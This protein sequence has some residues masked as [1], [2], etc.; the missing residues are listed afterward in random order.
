MRQSLLGVE[1]FIDRGLPTD[2]DKIFWRCATDSIWE[3]RLTATRWLIEFVGIKQDKNGNPA[4]KRPSR[5]DVLLADL[6]GALLAHDTPQGKFLA[7][8]WKGCSQASSHATSAY[9]HNPVNENELVRTLTI[10][11]DH[12]QSTLYQGARENIR[13]YVLEVPR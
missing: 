4:P 10:I 1:A 3:G 2:Q 11:I 13:D 12:L 5:S 8:V 7:D 9:N 6:G